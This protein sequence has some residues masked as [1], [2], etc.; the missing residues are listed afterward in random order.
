MNHSLVI[1]L[2]LTILFSSANVYGEL[3][4]QL[5]KETVSPVN[6]PVNIRVKLNYVPKDNFV[7]AQI[8]DPT[9]NSVLE[10]YFPVDQNGEF[11]ILFVGNLAFGIPS[12]S[13]GIYV[14]KITGINNN[15]T[16]TDTNF[17]ALHTKQQSLE[18]TE[19]NNEKSGVILISM[20]IMIFFIIALVLIL[21]LK[22]YIIN[23]INSKNH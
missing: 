13:E 14:I 12:I 8:I 22:K 23:R 20:I 17:F 21:K 15:N 9:G 10:R 1:L 4:V 3:L 18:Q 19:K 11:D 2:F 16:V 6:D 5:D 7:Y